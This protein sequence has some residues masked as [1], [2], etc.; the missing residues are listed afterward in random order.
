MFDW[1]PSLRG[2]LLLLALVESRASSGA[3]LAATCGAGQAGPPGA[4]RPVGLDAADGRGGGSSLLQLGSKTQRARVNSSAAEEEEERE[5]RDAVAPADAAVVDLGGSHAPK[6]PMGARSAAGAPEPQWRHRASA[7][8]HRASDMAALL[9]EAAMT[10][11]RG[12]LTAAS[13]GSGSYAVVTIGALACVVSITAYLFL[14]A[15]EKDATAPAGEHGLLQKDELPIP[16]EREGSARGVSDTADRVKQI[17]PRLGSRQALV[18]HRPG[19]TSPSPGAAHRPSLPA[20]GSSPRALAVPLS[21]GET[22]AATPVGTAVSLTARESPLPPPRSPVHSTRPLEP[23][24]LPPEPPVTSA[25]RGLCPGLVVPP[26]QECVLAIQALSDLRQR[27]SHESPLSAQRLAPIAHRFDILDLAGKPVLTAHIVR[28]WPQ[29]ASAFKQRPPV[30]TV[31]SLS[32]NSVQ[33]DKLTF[34]RA[35]GEGGG[36]RVMYIYDKNDVLFGSIKQDVTRP[37]MRYVL[38]SSRGRL[39]LL[40]EGDFQRRKVNVFSDGRDMLSRSEPCNM[41]AKPNGN[42]CQVRIGAGV[43][44]GLIVSGLLSIDAI[45]TM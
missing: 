42:F 37:A 39:Q 15:P 35:G 29:E 23:V 32:P 12:R 22:P 40:F 3:G 27:G 10:R 11:L 19:L 34:C 13:G 25:T 16:R 30:I 6:P 44:V 14:Q 5:A 26:N 31:C 33:E 36:R 18:Q 17:G 21:V 41:M 45:E 9:M 24:T 8:L 4:C 38:T 1:K 2:P 28:P 43:D 7:A 20:S